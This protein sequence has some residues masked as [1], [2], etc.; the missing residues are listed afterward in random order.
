MPNPKLPNNCDC[1]TNENEVE[2]EG[3]DKGESTDLK[4]AERTSDDFDHPETIDS[5]DGLTNDHQPLMAKV[6]T[7]T[8]VGKCRQL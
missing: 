4:I 6:S 5:P 3:E 7:I 8:L 1:E 2:D